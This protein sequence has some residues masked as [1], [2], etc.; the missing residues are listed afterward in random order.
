MHLATKCVDPAITLNKPF[1]PHGPKPCS[2]VST[3]DEATVKGIEADWIVFSVM[4]PHRPHRM[5]RSFQYMLGVMSLDISYSGN[6]H[7]GE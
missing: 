5:D 2:K 6:K 4:M 3:F 7:M 1:V